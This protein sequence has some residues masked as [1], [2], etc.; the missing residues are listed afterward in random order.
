[1]SRTAGLDFR[2]QANPSASNLSTT[3]LYSS[4]NLTLVACRDESRSSFRQKGPTL[5]SIRDCPVTSSSIV[6]PVAATDD[7]L[8]D[9]PHQ[10]TDARQPTTNLPKLLW[11]RHSG[12]ADQSKHAG[13]RPSGRVLIAG[14]QVTGTCFPFAA[15]ARPSR[16][17]V[18]FKNAL[19]AAP[20]QRLVSR[21]R[22]LEKPP[23]GSAIS[24]LRSG[25]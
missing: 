14:C 15:M 13:F 8:I 22:C 17:L 16:S 20:R 24:G 2:R 5:T 9:A 19:S 4:V 7:R 11:Q 10:P 6:F 12:N 21:S 3:S 25:G 23:A 18:H 1:M